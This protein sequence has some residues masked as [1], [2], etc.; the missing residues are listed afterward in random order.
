MSK[1]YFAASDSK[2]CI[3]TVLDKANRW[4]DFQTSNG[5]H[6][7]IY[8][9]YRA[10]YGQYYDSTGHEISFG[11]EQGEL[12]QMGV[13]H[14]RNI[15]QHMLVM[16][17]GTRPSMDARATNT[18]YKSQ[19]QT[20]LAN[21]ILE[22][23]MREKDL[24]SY[25]RK[26]VEYAIISGAGY[27]KLE[28]D[29][30]AGAV[31]DFDV[32]EKLDENG[33]VIGEEPDTSKPLYEGDIR[34][35]NLTA[36]D[37]VYDS[38]REDQNHDW[39]VCRSFK[40]KYDLASKY[41]EF[42]DEIVDLNTKDKE[43]SIRFAS[44]IFSDDTDLIPVYE[45]YHAKT[46]AVPNGRYVLFLTEDIVLFD[47]DMPYRRMPI[48]RVSPSDI[49]GT[50]FGYTPIFDLLPLQDAVNSLYS[51]ILTNQNAFAVQN[52]FVPRNADIVV[53]NLGGGMNVIEGN[54]QPV[55]LNLTQ[56]PREVF[57]FLKILIKDME[58]ISGVNST[59]RGN[60]E[61]SLRSGTSLALVQ[62]LALQFASNLQQQYIKAIENLGTSII[63]M[64]KDFAVTKRTISMIS[65]IS[66]RSFIQEFSGDDLSNVS[67]VV[68]D[69]GNAI[70]RTTAGKIQLAENMVQY[71]LIKDPQQYLTVVNT[72]KLEAATEDTQKQLF[73]IK[74]ENEMMLNGEKPVA[75]SV[76]SHLQHIQNHH[77]ILFD[78][79]LKKDVNLVT[80]VLNHIQEHIDLL[81]NTDPTLLQALGQQP[82]PPEGMAPMPGQPMMQAQ[83][84]PNTGLP[85][86]LM[87]PGME[88]PVNT[89]QIPGPPPP[90]EN[91]PTTPQQ[92]L[93]QQTG[94]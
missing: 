61:S 16:T 49:M 40:N 42:Y 33:N 5:F 86:E 15:A 25:I 84:D 8:S 80:L 63:E 59:T 24:E 90:F 78:P 31:Y 55:P 73:L 30:T 21:N 93:E 74:A 39:V 77:S 87:M 81:R 41:P 50:P 79:E 54:A 19:V 56:T 60:P 57:E 51:S 76:E 26:A 18:D 58:T 62:S 9:A 43:F 13:N 68:V 37:V 89:P 91:A 38:H 36:L 85:P 1:I 75:I 64:L 44:G 72:G 45:M 70:S 29:S 82:L 71:G 23:Y 28:W 17:T 52:V 47:G 88:A 35:C 4:Y 94:R 46:D 92:A 67:R 83:V 3:R 66:N 11:G 7:K 65:G 14:L 6:S 22:Y 27:I 32:K 20:Y 34:V 12:A 2:T 53:K 10:Y 69:V 48:I